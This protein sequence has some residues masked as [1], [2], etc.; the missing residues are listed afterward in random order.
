MLKI[1]NQL[2]QIISGENGILLP[3]PSVEWYAG[4]SSW[5]TDKTNVE[6]L[7]ANWDRETELGMVEQF[8]QTL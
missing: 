5:K 8:R 4:K 1:N 6:T 3:I 7:H 2:Q